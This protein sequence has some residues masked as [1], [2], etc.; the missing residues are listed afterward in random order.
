[1][2]DDIEALK[3]QLA[4]L[5]QKIAAQEAQAAA[6]AVDQHQHA[7][8]DLINSPQ[9]INLGTLIYGRSTSDDERRRSTT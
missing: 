5:Q 2:S 3:R 9:I 7:G 8:R 4:E 6:P 1:M